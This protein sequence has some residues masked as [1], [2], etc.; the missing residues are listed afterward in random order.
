M[1]L[2]FRVLKV[3]N[4]MLLKAGM[5]LVKL[6]REQL[7]PDTL[8]DEDLYGRPENQYLLFQPWNSPCNKVWFRKEVTRNTMLSRQK[9]YYMLRL[10]E[11]AL[12]LPG[13]VFEAGVGSGGSA[14]L[15]IDLIEANRCSKQLWLLDTFKGYQN[16]HPAKDGTHVK[17]SD[18]RCNSLED[19]KKLLQSDRCQ[20]HFVEGIIPDTL[21]K[22]E[23][24][25]F[26]FAH[27]D[28]NLYEPTKASFEFVL[29][30]LCKSGVIV[31]DDYNWPAT[32]GARQAID[33]VC[34]QHKLQP[35][36][37]P[38]STQAFLIR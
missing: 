34:A 26:C 18:C 31:F 30:R 15:M 14:R 7:I 4:S 19:V 10:M 1:A 28:V 17:T 25:Q 24:Q 16:I 6:P 5:K 36:S 27:I 37:V 9:L 38:A 3:L 35:I 23:S 20:I 21:V 8:P 22:V 33:E 12:S 13:D 2:H 11:H 32:Y 29:S